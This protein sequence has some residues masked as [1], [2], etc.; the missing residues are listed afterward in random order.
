MRPIWHKPMRPIWLKM[1]EHHETDL[2][3]AVP[4]L[5]S[6]LCLVFSNY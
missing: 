2:A 4:I 5:F 1:D 3:Q 6:V